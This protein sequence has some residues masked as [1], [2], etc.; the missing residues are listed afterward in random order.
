MLHCASSAKV[1]RPLALD[2][3]VLPEAGA[4]V[5]VAQIQGCVCE[6]SRM[7]PPRTWSVSVRL[8]RGR[9]LPLPLA[10]ATKVFSPGA[11]P[12]NTPRSVRL[13]ASA[14]K[15]SPTS[16]PLSV[17]V[18]FV[19]GTV[20]GT[21]TSTSA[22]PSLSRSARLDSVRI[23]KLNGGSSALTDATLASAPTGIAAAPPPP[24]PATTSSAMPSAPIR[25]PWARLMIVSSVLCLVGW[26]I[27]SMQ[28]IDRGIGKYRNERACI[29]QPSGSRDER[30]GRVGTR[31]RSPIA[32]AG[33]QF[34][35]GH[36]RARVRG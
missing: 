5:G 7:G 19:I 36:P 35:R 8:A 20:F 30:A 10:S 27:D 11:M 26:E 15:R 22:S 14:T 23:S 9:P 12:V 13:S 3:G 2:A 4:G 32:A 24:H 6:P 28:R 33:R 17:S 31:S 1:D 25:I 16:T 21:S 18:T 29:A 34:P